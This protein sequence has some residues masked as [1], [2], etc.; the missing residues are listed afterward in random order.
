[1]PVTY[2][3][4]IGSQIEAYRKPDILSVLQ[5]LPDNTQKLISPKD[6]RDAFLST[7]ANSPFKQTKNTSG[8][9]YI[10]IDSGNPSDRD[11]K[12]KIFL[13]KRSF[14]NTDILTSSLLSSTNT[15]IFIF[16]TKPDSVL[17]NT[18]IV[19]FLAGTNSTLY[20][21]AP[22]ISSEYVN[23]SGIENINLEIRNPS[24]YNG[25][26]NIYSDNGRVSINGI[27]FPTIAENSAA[28]N[29]KILRYN[30]TFPNGYFKWDDSNVSISQLGSPNEVTNIYGGTVSLNGYELE[31]VN[32]SIVPNT[33]GGIPMG[34]S[35]SS[36]SFNG[37]KW[38]I[39]E[40][41]RKLLYPYVAP[42][43]NTS[44]NIT[45]AELGTTSS[46]VFN[47]DMTIFPRTSNEY[48][49][50]YMIS[51]KT[52]NTTTTSS[53]TG[54]SFSGIPGTTF[55]G[56]A[57]F[58][59]GS[60]SSPTTTTYTLSVS[61]IWPSNTYPLGFSHSATSSVQFIYPIYYGFSNTNI[62]DSTS[63][64]LALNDLSK[65]IYPYPGLSNSISLN[66]NG[67][68]YMYFIYQTSTFPTTP[69]KIIDPNGF[70]VYGDTTSSFNSII[71][72]TKV[73]GFGGNWSILA[74][75]AICSYVSTID[76]FEILF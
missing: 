20:P 28:T 21:Y 56:V 33:V 7:W 60:Y 62:T 14:S 40:V 72:L 58:I 31:F 18:T 54:L 17:Q 76:K 36:T 63:F 34:F 23:N 24:L 37:T 13:G 73:N 50:N 45:Y 29:G 4:N 8:V 3:V 41:L 26:I 68:G 55:S 57:N 74:S 27:S 44:T 66:Y 48:I 51:S 70:V 46:I 16:N 11:I 65:Y 6:V 47:W 32:P 10:G 64:D 49:S 25:A 61:D 35:F 43:I 42:V 53:Y 15:D 2:S 5:D 38:P 39:S 30:G 75:S 71:N 69:I 52:G 12:Q 22:Y 67:S 19:S 1:M 59:T 9:E